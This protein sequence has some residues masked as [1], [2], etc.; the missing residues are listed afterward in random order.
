MNSLGLSISSDPTH[1][2]P[3]SR[4]QLTRPESTAEALEA[5]EAMK[6]FVIKRDE[7]ALEQAVALYVA[8]AR[9]RE[10]SI[11]TVLAMLCQLASGL[12]GPRVV[13]ELLHNPTKMHALIFAGILRAFYGNAAV[14]RG[15]GAGAQRKADASQH[16]ESGTWPKRPAD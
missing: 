15:I 1:I 3:D 11:E 13:D 8:S 2:P 4:Q 9:A 14:E 10:E 16:V 5:L 6:L 7:T 12:E